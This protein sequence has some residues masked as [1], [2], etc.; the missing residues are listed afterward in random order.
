MARPRTDIRPRVLHAARARFLAQ[1][2]EG[3]SLRDIA[4]DAKT[5]VGM[6][7][8]YFPTKDDL[9]LAVVEEVYVGLLADLEKALAPGPTARERLERASRRLGSASADELSVIRLIV[10]EAL[11]STERFDR[12]FQRFQRGHIPLIV[13]ALGDGVTAGEIDAGLPLP[14]LL[15]ATLGTIALP[16]VIRRVAGSR[17]PFSLLPEPESLAKVGAGVL[18]HG[19]APAPAKSGKK[20]R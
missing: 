14:L 8:Y 4:R 10:H 18:F 19:V 12:L 11:L 1:G 3:S 7:Y 6:V 13:A 5:S 20:R 17:A 2:V 16:Q 15:V 9:F